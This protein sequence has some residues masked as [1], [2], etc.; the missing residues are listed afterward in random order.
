MLQPFRS[1]RRA[2]TAASI[3]VAFATVALT[4]VAASPAT[5]PSWAPAAADGPRAVVRS[6]IDFVTSSGCGNVRLR[7][8]TTP[9]DPT[10]LARLP[11]TVSVS[12]PSRDLPVTP[13]AFLTVAN[14]GSTI[15]SPT[16]FATDPSG[17]GPGIVVTLTWNGGAETE[18][19]ATSPYVDRCAGVFIPVEPARLLD[20]RTGA[21]TSTGRPGVVAAGTTI[22]VDPVAAGN[23]PLAFVT[24]VV[25]NV[26]ATEPGTA[27]YLTAYPC[28]QDPPNASNV[29]F[30]AG[31]TVPNLVVVDLVGFPLTGRVCIYSSAATHV[32]ADVTGFYAV[33]G[34]IDEGRITPLPAPQRLLDTRAGEPVAAGSVRRVPIAGRGGI[35]EGGV[36]AVAM[37]VTATDAA[38]PG[39]LT[40]FPCDTAQPNASNVNYRAARAV[41]NAAIV[42]L[43]TGGDLCIFSSAMAHVIVDVVSYVS[44][45]STQIY[46]PTLPT[47]LWD[48]RT[49]RFSGQT[50]ARTLPAN[51]TFRYPTGYA[52]GTVLTMNV[53]IAEPE[54]PGYATVYPCDQ[55]V[56]NA[57]NLNF[58]AGGAIANT[59]FVRVDA[60]GDVCFRS[61]ATAHFIY[62]L[63]G[64]SYTPPSVS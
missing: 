25:L 60:N 46:L 63:N 8:F 27:G 39:Y 45:A 35:A 48:S 38:A 41:A 54:A 37:N 43:G 53:T 20:T 30:D 32:I 59:V 33:N 52:S 24:A 55:G 17:R 3:V 19:F 18:S 14:V 12:E 42:G 2:F 47:R 50:V 9:T 10:L 40:V 51:S 57:S 7:G 61:T 36:S 26:T 29:N 34:L 62:D 6:G 15:E 5:A 28:G 16:L 1:L 49:M 13:I 4:P 58:A 44:A 64:T 31:E 56:P 22:D 23:V 21:G 11:L